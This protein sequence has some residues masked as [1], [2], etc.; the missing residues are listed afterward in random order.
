MPAQVHPE[1]LLCCSRIQIYCE[2]SFPVWRKVSDSGF[3]PATLL[4]GAVYLNTPVKQA[5]FALFTLERSQVGFRKGK[6]T[7]SGLQADIR[8]EM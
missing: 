4:F 3:L 2:E 7:S 5:V 8:G 1:A 6:I